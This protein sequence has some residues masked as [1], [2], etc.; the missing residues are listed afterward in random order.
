MTDVVLDGKLGDAAVNVGV[1]LHAGK[2]VEGRRM[3]L[4]E[5]HAAVVLLDAARNPPSN[6]GTARGSLLLGSTT[7]PSYC[8]A[9]QAIHIRDQLAQQ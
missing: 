9:W 3:E 2:L 8:C 1:R 5:Q 7:I 6:L 4:V